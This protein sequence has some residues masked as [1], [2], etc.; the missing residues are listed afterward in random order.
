MEGVGIVGKENVGH[1]AAN[2]R[3]DAGESLLALSAGSAL[4][5][6]IDAEEIEGG[7]F[8]SNLRVFV[9]QQ[10]HAG[11]CV[12]IGRFVFRAG[13]DFVVA[14]AA[15]GAEV[16]VKTA[17]F[18]DAI[19]DG[20]AGASDEIAGDNGQIGSEI[21]GH[22]HGAA[23][24]RAGHVA[25]EVNVADL[26]DLHAV[27]SGRQAG[28][29]NLDAADLVVES[30]GSEAIHGAEERGGTGRSG[31][32]AEKV[33]AAGVGNR[34]GG[35]VSGRGSG[36][37]RST[38][39]LR[40]GVMQKMPEAFQHMNRFDRDISEERA[41]KPEARENTHHRAVPGEG[42][43]PED[44]ALHHGYDHQQEKN[45]VDQPGAD[46]KGHAAPVRGDAPKSAVPETLR[47]IEQRQDAQS[48]GNAEEKK[49]P[50]HSDSAPKSKL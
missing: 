47:E 40:G 27:K 13:V 10:F 2:E 46:A 31:G 49:A 8:E 42:G 1:V 48:D 21:I 4:A 38:R 28:Q 37:G 33:A 36:R 16:G 30:L 3:L 44:Q 23:H 24:L 11:L 34:L 6:V 14:V 15:P 26:D 45:N 29:R 39:S 9:A 12:K 22:V 32:G 41:E 18:V 20:I 5:L 35:F 7:A 17:D 19:G 25:A 43:A 50:I